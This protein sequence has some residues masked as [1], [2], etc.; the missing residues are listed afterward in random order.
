MINNEKFNQA[1]EAG[2]RAVRKTGEFAADV[3][4]TARI[5][6]RIRQVQSDLRAKYREMGKLC[7]AR[8]N[9]GAQEFDDGM[10]NL[11][12]EIEALKRS[13][14]ALHA[15]SRF[16]R[17]CSLSVELPDAV[18][19]C[20]LQSRTDAFPYHGASVTAEPSAQ[21]SVTAGMMSLSDL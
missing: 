20:L 5:R 17:F 18:K 6:F 1:V 2:K 12:D 16:C 15:A 9:E 21:I 4:D 10:R 8:M 19:D 11:F 13:L 7:C 3:A 14:A